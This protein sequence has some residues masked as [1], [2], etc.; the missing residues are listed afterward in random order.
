MKRPGL[1]MAEA[2]VAVASLVIATVVLSTILSNARTATSTSR[3]YLIAQNL[4]TESIEA[5]KNV[6]DTNWLLYPSRRECWLVIGDCPD[7]DPATINAEANYLTTE[8]NGKWQLEYKQINNQAGQPGKLDIE[9]NAAS[10]SG[11]FVLHLDPNN[12]RYVSSTVDGVNNPSRFYRSVFVKSVD[13]NDDKA[14]FEVKVEW[15]DGAKVR[16]VTRKFTIYNYL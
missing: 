6:R 11:N 1:V 16:G 7:N 14:V 15:R 13:A 5:V 10:V 12:N 4:I 9:T 3:D 8:I 2:L